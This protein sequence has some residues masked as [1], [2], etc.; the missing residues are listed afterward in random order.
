[1]RLTQVGINEAVLSGQ[2]RASAENPH[3]FDYSINWQIRRQFGGNLGSNPGNQIKM[4]H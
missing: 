2:G 4:R 1:M 3:S